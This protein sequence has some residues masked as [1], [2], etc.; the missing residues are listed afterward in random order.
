MSVMSKQIRLV[1]IDEVKTDP[2]NARQHPERNLE[3]IKT[4]LRVY[5]QRK[6]IVVNQRTGIIEAGNGLWMAAKALGWEKIAVVYVDDDPTMAMGYSIMDNR[7][8]ELAEWD[9][10]VLGSLIEEL[11][12]E[13]FDL[14]FTGFDDEELRESLPEPSTDGL[15]GGG[16]LAKQFLV[17]PL[18][19]LDARKGWWINRKKA[20]ISLGIQS[21]LGR[22]NEG[23]GTKH[24]LVLSNGAQPFRVYQAK[25][26]YE[27]AV[28]HK[29]SWDEFYAAYPDAAVQPGTSI[30][31]PV[32]TELVYRWFCPPGGVVLDPFAGGSVR[33]IV[34]CKLGRQY[35]GVDLS[36]RQVEAN[37]R[38]AEVLCKAP[39]IIIDDP[40]ALTPVQK[41]GDLW[42][43]RDDLFSVAGVRGGKARTCWALAK[44]AA[45][46]V[47]AGSRQS[48]QV[49]IVAHIAREL[50]VPCR[51]HTP[52]GELSPEVRQAQECGAEV[53]QHKAGYNNV[54]IARA[55]E[56][57][58][59]L[60]WTEIPFGMECKEAVAQTR[61]QVAN[62]PAEAKRLVIPVGSGMSLAGVLWG[63]H[64]HNINIPVLGVCVGADPT[65]RL[66]KYAPPDW[67]EMVTLKKSPLDYHKAAPDTSLGDIVLDEI[68]EAKCLP[69]LEPGDCL[70]VVGIRATA[71]IDQQ[72]PTW[73]VGDSRN[74]TSLAEG[75]EADL[76]FSCP[77]YADLEVYSDDPADLSTLPYEDFR[78]DY[79]AII[80]ETCKMLKPNRFACFV[81]GE[82]RDKRGHYRNFVGDTIQAFRDAGLE[83][84]NE[85]ILVTMIGSYSV[86]AR[87]PF[88]ATRKLRKTHQNVLIFVKG[89]A[90]KA[91]EAIG[92]VETGDPFEFAE[93][94]V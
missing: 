43:K 58:Q 32:L 15:S 83:Y 94:E 70:W 41:V 46:L 79:A 10:E 25:A 60:G 72:R 65:K 38:Q 42:V 63:L 51:V 21:E 7:S 20:W 8:A 47:T 23:D 27:T 26:R 62:L 67:R 92:S 17:P 33:G 57:A 35:V 88:E 89:D 39:E 36:E 71:A 24:G 4:S 45:G 52:T 28:G 74:I 86:L 75:V 34:A 37:R 6:P 69:F 9:D 30:F 14:E 48:P 1:N 90:K 87:R 76:V 16:T 61:R 85:A 54:I 19:V 56:D 40:E 11:K 66:D 12:L 49:N 73:I 13:D 2:R 68:Y 84:Y 59:R 80:A 64:D 55:R 82:V 29:V 31:D 44:G 91:T 18:S 78:R 77:P 53:V 22:G 93:E 5:G 81:V 50:G 3:T